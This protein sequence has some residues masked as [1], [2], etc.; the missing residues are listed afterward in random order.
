M[1]HDWDDRNGNVYGAVLIVSVV[2]KSFYVEMSAVWGKFL[3]SF[4]FLHN[5]TSHVIPNSAF[6]GNCLFKS[7]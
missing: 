5:T 6:F 1:V 7:V 4:H 2:I 3:V